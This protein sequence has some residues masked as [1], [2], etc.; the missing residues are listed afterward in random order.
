MIFQQ[1]NHQK[2]TTMNNV[3]LPQYRCHKV[4]RA[5][6][7]TGFRQNGM[8]GAADILLGELNGVTTMLPEFFKKHQPEVGGYLVQYED[9]YTSYSPAKAF[10][11][12]YT[13][14][15]ETGEAKLS[16]LQQHL[17]VSIVQDAGEAIEK[18]FLYREPEYEGIS[19]EQI[20]VVRDGTIEG[21]PTVDFVLKD[22]TGKKFV[23]MLTGALVKSI[24]C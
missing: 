1:L 21:N 15:E 6:K 11:S 4:V 7:I 24:P 3:Q 22:S 19:I 16:G 9:G 18:G 10:E 20:V 17:A 8:Q 2:T 23:V 12:G 5:A 13:R 14:I